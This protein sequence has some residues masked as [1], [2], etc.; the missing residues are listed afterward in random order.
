MPTN[1]L[2][3]LFIDT[4]VFLRFLILDDKNPQMSVKARKLFALLEA[5]KLLLQTNTLVVAEI[6]YVLEG[7]YE[8][9]KTQVKELL[10]PILAI[11]NLL[12]ND[13]ETI[14]SALNL[15]AEKNIDFEDAY[16]YF[17]MINEGIL[18]IVTFDEKHFK[19]LEGITV[20]TSF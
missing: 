8:I 18:K 13:K 9:P 16:T 12:I 11:P 2:N 14:L 4:N 17:D 6:V 1:S 5:K 3:R 15:F 20:V 19:R 7:Y 10:L